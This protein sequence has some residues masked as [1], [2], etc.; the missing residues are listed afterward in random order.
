MNSFVKFRINFSPEWNGYTNTAVFTRSD[1]TDSF[2]VYNVEHEKEYYVPS[3][4]IA[5]EGVC[6]VNVIGTNGESKLATSNSCF[7]CIE[8][9]ASGE[10]NAESEVTASLFAQICARIEAAIAQYFSKEIVLSADE[11]AVYWK[12]RDETSAPL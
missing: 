8:S 6:F 10:N 11:N 7:F 1:R 5:K 4:A 2:Y 9:A 12:Y 3:E